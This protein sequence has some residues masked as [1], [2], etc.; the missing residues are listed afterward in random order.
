[1]IRQDTPSGTYS[2][3]GT[4]ADTTSANVTMSITPSAGFQVFN[5]GTL[6]SQTDSEGL[7]VYNASG[8]EEVAAGLLNASPAIYGLAVLPYGESLLQQVGGVIGYTGGGGTATSST[9]VSLTG[10]SRRRSARHRPRSSP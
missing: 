8:T 1:M 2:Y 4:T 6:V 9:Q 10:G 7:H 5:A 3:D